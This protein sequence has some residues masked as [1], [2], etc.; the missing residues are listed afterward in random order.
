[1]SAETICAVHGQ[2]RRAFICQHLLAT[3]EDEVPRGAFWCRDEDQC[4]NGYC[5]E[6]A[7][8]LEAVG[9]EWTDDLMARVDVKLICEGCFR[10]IANLN[11]FSELD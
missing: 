7:A 11:G 6:C 2:S 4:I 3:L 5:A 8:R 9:G 10:G 1:M